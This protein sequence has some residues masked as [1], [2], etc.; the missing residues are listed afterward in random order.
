MDN[1]L[2]EVAF[3]DKAK[4]NCVIVTS[5]GNV[6]T[7]TIM[8]RR[9]ANDKPECIDTYNQNMNGCYHADQQVKYYEM[10]K[11]K[12][13]K[14]WKKN[15]FLLELTVINASIIH[16]AKRIAVGMTKL[17]LVNFKNM[18][19]Q[20]LTAAACIERQEAPREIQVPV[21]ALDRLAPESHF[22]ETLKKDRNCR[23]CS[24]PG[25]RKRTVHVCA[26]CPGKPHLCEGNC[27]KIRV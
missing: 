4:K 5:N 6:A 17:E 13:Y 21:Q 16:N 22:L 3:R 20:Q 12:R 14:W 19:I 18:L 24:E 10:H 11:R 15:Y 2:F 1:S 23:V 25:N 27:F 8:T 9:E 7:K 26:T